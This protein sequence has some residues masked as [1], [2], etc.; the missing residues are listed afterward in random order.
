MSEVAWGTVADWVGAV[1]TS[2]ALFVA[3]AVLAIDLHRSRR[4]QAVSVVTWSLPWGAEKKA[5]VKIHNLSD[6]PIFGLALLVLSRPPKE[7]RDLVYVRAAM[8][9]GIDGEFPAMDLPH[10]PDEYACTRWVEYTRPANNFRVDL[11]PGSIETF[12]QQL[13]YSL[14]CYE[15]YVGFEDA[16]GAPWLKSVDTQHLLNRWQKWNVR[17]RFDRLTTQEL[18]NSRRRTQGT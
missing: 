1:G 7:L 12:E 10:A 5:N 17:K 16:H 2:G 3:A 13:E 9:N 11:Q 6:K 8:T 15:F 4:S 18:L 14:D